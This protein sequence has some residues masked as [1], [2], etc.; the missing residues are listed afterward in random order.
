MNEE[1]IVHFFCH[2]NITKQLWDS[3]AAAC[4]GIQF[5][6]LTPKSAYFGFHPLRE[7][8]VNHVHLIFRIAL[9]KKRDLGTCS[10]SY[11]LNKISQ[12]KKSEENLLF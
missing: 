7:S 12:I 11:I 4:P 9:Y 3:L 5:P 8:L 1:T 10:L 6:A 2:C